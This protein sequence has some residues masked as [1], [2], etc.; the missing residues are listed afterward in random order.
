MSGAIVNKVEKS[1]IITLDLSYYAPKKKNRRVGFETVFI[2][3]FGSERKA[4]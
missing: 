4:I 1:G 3:R 2:S